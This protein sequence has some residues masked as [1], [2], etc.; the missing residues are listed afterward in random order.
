M[1]SLFRALSHAL[2]LHR[3]R[4]TL[5]DTMDRLGVLV[6]DETRDLQQ[7]Q[8]P[9]FKQMVR[10]HRNHPSIMAWSFCNEGGC[11]SGSNHSLAS[12]FRDVAYTFDG[13]RK[14]SGNMRKTVGPGTLSDI[15]DVQ[16]LSHPAGAD[17]DHVHD[18]PSEA[19]K[20]LIASECCS[21]MTMRGENHRNTSKVR[22]VPSNFNADCLAEQVNRSDDG[23]PFSVGSMV[24]VSAAAAGLIPLLLRSRLAAC[25]QL[26]LNTCSRP[27][28]TTSASRTS[29]RGR[30]WRARTGAL[31]SPASRKLPCG[32]TGR[33][34]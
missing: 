27:C 17:L 10:Q 6:W 33:S 2:D 15:L 1:G 25:L 26:L 19:S 22:P 24:W 7:E 9:A 30:T 11:G 8:L 28:S 20:A 23:R 4:D 14:V 3:Y 16:G 5:Y 34:G 32:G 18:L 12:A 13:T 29:M 31:M 21:C